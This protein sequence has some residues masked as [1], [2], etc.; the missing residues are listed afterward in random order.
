M[1]AIVPA[2]LTRRAFLRAGAAAGMSLPALR[3][4]T[5][6]ASGKGGGGPGDVTIMVGFG[7]GNAPNQVP[8]QEQVAKSLTG[9]DGVTRISFD[10]CST[11]T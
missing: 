2:V 11:A 4:L 9:K 7:T 5:A 10:R 3:I 8:Y 1:G 6:C